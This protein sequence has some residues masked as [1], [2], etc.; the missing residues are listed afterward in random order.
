MATVSIRAARAPSRRGRS[1]RGR[2]LL[3]RS[4]REA[5]RRARWARRRLKGAPRWA[6]IGVALSILLLVSA[7]ANLAYQVA[8]KPT[9]LFFPIGSALDKSPAETWRDYGPLFRRYST[10]AIPPELLAALAQV[11]GAGNPVART[12]WRWRLTW[13]PFGLYEP[14]SSAVGMYQMTDGAFAEARRFCIRDHAVV[15][16]CW[17]N[18]LYTRVLPSHAI[19]LAAIYL[20]RK[21]AAILAER[22]PLH[23]SARQKQDLAAIVHL[24]GA[25]PA[26]AFARRGFRLAPGERCGDH[27]AAAYLSGVHGM[28]RRFQSLAAED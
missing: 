19:E 13:H 1:R 3:R 22:P 28:A 27:A 5:R 12:Y 20:D 9:E 15:E 7:A 16:E 10:A 23:A 17:L 26:R 21:V 4:L 6:Q 24:C 25:G 2:S 18:G 14:A 11:E 8:R